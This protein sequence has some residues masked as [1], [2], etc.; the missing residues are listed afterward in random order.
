MGKIGNLVVDNNVLKNSDEWA[1]FLRGF[2][3]K[4]ERFGEEVKSRIL[5]T[6]EEVKNNSVKGLL[7]QIAKESESQRLK[8][9]SKKILKKNFQG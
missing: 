9:V 7:E 8:E 6:I 3:L 5:G 4:N 1:Q 2:I